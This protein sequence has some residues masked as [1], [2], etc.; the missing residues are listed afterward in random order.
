MAT[1]ADQSQLREIW[2]SAF[3]DC[4]RLARIVIPAA[5]CELESATFN[6]CAALS[7]IGFD[8]EYQLRRLLL[9]ALANRHSLRIMDLPSLWHR[10]S[11]FFIRGRRR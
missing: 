2:E 10:Q 6:G 11:R 3:A 8:A 7:S 5:V 1:F 4:V 9:A